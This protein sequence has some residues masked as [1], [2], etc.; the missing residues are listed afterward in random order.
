MKLFYKNFTILGL[1]IS[2]AVILFI[3]ILVW[4]MP[5]NNL[6]LNNF[7]KSFSVFTYYMHP[8]QSNLIVEMAELG[9]WANS[10]QCQFFAGQFRL[11]GLSK[12]TI[13]QSYFKESMSTGVYFL[14]EDVFNHSPWS[15]W[16]E[17]YLGN[18]VPQKDKNIYLVWASDDNNLPDGD[19]RCH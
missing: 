19:I 11:S 3:I 4:K 2:S 7:R 9:N 8:K 1:I 13:M 14:D 15:E 16:K 18:Y 10:N 5:Y 12:E 17:K 6:Y